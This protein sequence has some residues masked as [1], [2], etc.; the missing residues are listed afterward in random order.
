MKFHPLGQLIYNK[1]NLQQIFCDPLNKGEKWS[2]FMNYIKWHIFYKFRNKSWTIRFN[3]GLK[4][5]VQ[6]YPDHDAGEVNIWTNNVDYY[7]LK[8]IESILGD[9]DVIFDLGCNVGNR[10][11][12]LAH[13]LKG[14][15]LVDAGYVAYQR[16]KDHLALNQ[17]DPKRFQAFN[18][19]I[20]DSNKQVSFTN[21]GGADTRNQVLDEVDSKDSYSIQ[22][23]TIDELVH[24]TK[25]SPSIIKIDIEGQD[26]PALY[27]ARKTLMK[28]N[29]KLVMFERVRNEP[30]QPVIDYFDEIGWKIFAMDRSGKLIKDLSKQT[31]F[32][33]FSVPESQYHSIFKN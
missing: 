20:G 28:G 25:V 9:D 27:G 2:F 33:L 24:R 5:I 8:F 11:L 6:P 4:S 23:I 3:N 12:A 13:K 30:L 32:N 15:V 10:T 26:I 18:L 19:A 21:Y 7:E 31:G 29:V 1:R 14:A 22:M 16:T 17:L